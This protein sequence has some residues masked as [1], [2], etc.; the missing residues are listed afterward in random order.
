MPMSLYK[1][2]ADSSLESAQDRIGFSGST[3]Q[4]LTKNTVKSITYLVE[5]A[6]F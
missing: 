6:S 2:R 3:F 5:A 1:K 4:K